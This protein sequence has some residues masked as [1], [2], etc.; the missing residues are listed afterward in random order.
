MW[1][2]RGRPSPVEALVTLPTHSDPAERRARFRQAI[3]AL[4]QESVDQRASPLDGIEPS[5]LVAACRVALGSGLCDDLD[6]ISEGAAGVALYELTAALPP[7]DERRE[8]GRRVFSRLYGGKAGT[9]VSVAS[10]MAWGAVRQL[11]SATMRAR[12]SL[13]FNLPLGG[14]VNADPLALSLVLR[15]PHFDSW[16]QKGARGALP[17]RRL[18]ALLLESAAREAVRRFHSGDPYPAEL[19]LSAHVRP[20][21]ERLIGDREPLVWRHAAVARGLLAAVDP[22][23][24]EEIDLLLDPALSPTEWRR[25]VVSLVACL[26]HDQETTRRQCRSLMQ[27]ELVRRHPGLL[28]TVVWGLTPVVAAEPEVAEE[29]LLDLAQTGRREIAE[30]MMELLR[31]VATPGFGTAAATMLARKVESTSGVYDAH[32]L[33]FLEPGHRR[34]RQV[35]DDSVHGW[36]RRAIVA[37]ETQGAKEALEFAREAIDR[38]AHAV[39]VLEK[40]AGKDDHEWLRVLVDLDT[41][42]LERSRLHDLLLLGR[43]AGDPNA[44]VPELEAVHE[45]LGGWLLSA[46]QNTPDEDDSEDALSTRRRRLVCFLHLLDVQ[47]TDAARGALVVQ[48]RISE[49][50]RTLLAN[51]AAGPPAPILRVMCATL[52][53]SFDAAIREGVADAPELLL[54]VLDHLRDDHLVRSIME[55]STDPGLRE[56]L[57]AYTGF[58][59]TTVESDG[60]APLPAVAKAFFDFSRGVARHGS[61]S[62][63]ALRQAL[64]KTG[65][66]LEVLSAA[67]GLTQLAAAENRSNPVEDLEIQVDVLRRLASMSARR[68]LSARPRSQSG[69]GLRTGSPTAML[70]HAVG[71]GQAL[72]RDAFLGTVEALTLDL[73]SAVASAVARVLA[74]IPS[75]PTTPPSDVTV[76]PMKPRRGAL[77]DW[78]MPRRTIGAFYVVSALG[79]G[80]VSSVFVA[81]RIEERRDPNAEVYALKVPEYDPST[82]RSLSEHEFMDLFRDEAGALLSLPRHTNLARFVNFDAT[83]K[84]KPILVMELIRGQSL[85]KLI[86][87]GLFTLPQAFL[88][89]NGVLGGL[90]AMHSVGVAHLDIKPSNVILRDENTPALVDFGLSGR[91][92]RPG[93]GTLEYCAPEVL[94]VV[95]E[96]VSPPAVAADIYAFGCL[97]Y[98]VLTGDLLFDADE[99]TALMSQHISHDGWPEPLQNLA[100]TPELHDLAVLIGSCLRR[101]PRLRPD[102]KS[103]RIALAEQAAAVEG[104][105]LA[106]PLPVQGI[107]A[108]RA[109]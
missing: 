41:A 104:S 8:F 100:A 26:V 10:R 78:L 16:V 5:A 55:A 91:Q 9:F 64:L 102:A 67:R 24:R 92:L 74:R 52:A 3:A 46:E 17:T 82:A 84:P 39:G 75:L 58:L 50:L 90:S 36:V 77:P 76:I 15:A 31:E 61:R 42:V 56:A 73:P 40:P 59:S 98:Q 89:L 65:R 83:A 79:A 97:A 68:V 6:W 94:G 14:G 57:E 54:L 35:A 7:G 62:G 107:G 49:A 101:D 109:V 11:D 37:Y 87:N 13:C 25:A 38:A 33:S 43:S 4:G 18:A 81:K 60:N 23:L 96:G 47:T 86:K 99:E 103:L 45:R 19:L 2:V 12:V 1:F 34:Q 21:Y 27:G 28:E 95:P 66:A 70:E 80:G 85:E 63:E 20:S 32:L 71:S 44:A 93:C 51:L 22:R 30:A 53:R 88:H 106:W 29:L 72:D 105:G 108:S 69:F 48:R